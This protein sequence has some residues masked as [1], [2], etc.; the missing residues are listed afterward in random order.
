[1][2]SAVLVPATD[3][4]PG[5]GATGTIISQTTIGQRPHRTQP[6][7]CAGRLEVLYL[8]PTGSPLSEDAPDPGCG[9]A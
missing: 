7:R 3:A 2:L 4:T 6:R 1:M 8:L 5:S 9:F